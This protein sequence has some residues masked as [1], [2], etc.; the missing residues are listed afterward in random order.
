M[1]FFSA[2]PLRP[3]LLGL[4]PF[5]AAV[6]CG[7]T[8]QPI[9][10]DGADAGSGGA[11]AEGQSSGGG[12]PQD[13]GGNASGGRVATDAPEFSGGSTGSGGTSS[14]GASGAGGQDEQ[15]GP[16]YDEHCEGSCEGNCDD[17]FTCNEDEILV[18]A[19]AFTT[20][21]GCDGVSFQLPSSCPTLG[22]DHDG[23]C[24]GPGASYDCNP[25]HITCLP[26]VAPEPCPT[27]EVYSVQ[28][29][30]YGECVPVGQCACASHAD[31]P[32]PSGTDEY[33]CHGT[34]DHCGPWL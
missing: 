27:G 19:A 31:C 4:L 18:C 17:G 8:L 33:A 11:T 23:A 28:S 9:D 24:E 13:D 30:C 14:G 21:C 29:S 15:T 5:A 12:S 32:D 10:G 34:T 1:A 22:Y 26:I 25:D 16:C 2:L 6:G 3:R 7:S 20:V